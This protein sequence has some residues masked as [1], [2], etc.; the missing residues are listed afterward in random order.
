MNASSTLSRLWRRLTLRLRAVRQVPE[1][2]FVPASSTVGV[3]QQ[4]EGGRSDTSGDPSWR[5]RWPKPLM[6]TVDNDTE[7][8]LKV[9][10]RMYRE[11]LRDTIRI[12]I[13]DV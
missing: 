2:L 12:S 7:L 6:F 10:V 4:P 11:T 3:H 1:S 9:G 8:N 5:S 13:R